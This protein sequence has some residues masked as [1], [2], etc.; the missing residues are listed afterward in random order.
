MPKGKKDGA[1]IIKPGLLKIGNTKY[2]QMI[3]GFCRKVDK[4]CAPLGYYESS[5]LTTTCCIVTQKKPEEHSSY[6]QMSHP[7]CCSQHEGWHQTQEAYNPKCLVP[8][9]KH[10]DGS[11]MI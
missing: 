9:V 6:G 7:S 3:S 4:N 8:T 10:G 11:L 1:M 2:G 5:F